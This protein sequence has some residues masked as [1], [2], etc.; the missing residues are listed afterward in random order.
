MGLVLSV[1]ASIAVSE[2]SRARYCQNVEA[3]QQQSLTMELHQRRRWPLEALLNNEQT[4]TPPVEV[5]DGNSHHFRLSIVIVYRL[6]RDGSRPG[7]NPPR[8]HVIVLE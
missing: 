5:E 1:C 7:K 2:N 4:L 6:Q 8:Y 3:E